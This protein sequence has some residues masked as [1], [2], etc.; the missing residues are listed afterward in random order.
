MSRGVGRD[1]LVGQ[2]C[3]QTVLKRAEAAF[4][5]SF[6]LRAG[7]DQMGDAQRRESPL[8]LRTWVAAIGGGLMAE[9]GQAVSIEGE[10]QAVSGKGTAEVLEMVPS[11]IGGHKDS[12][13]KLARMII[14]RQEQGLLVRCWPP[15]VDR[16]IVLPEFAHPCTFPSPSRP[17][18]WGRCVD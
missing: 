10:G 17:G 7:R 4:D 2:E 6:S 5:L 11:G 1:F 18:Y 14:D 13:Q 3:Q 9:E 15:L 12:P 16:R 8:E